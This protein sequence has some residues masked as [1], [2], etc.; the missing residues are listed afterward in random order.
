MFQNGKSPAML[1]DIFAGAGGISTIG[2]ASSAQSLVEAA[3]AQAGQTP[4]ATPGGGSVLASAGGLGLGLLL[5]FAI[6]YVLDRSVL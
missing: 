2:L 1:G 6:A 4:V 3:R 5:L